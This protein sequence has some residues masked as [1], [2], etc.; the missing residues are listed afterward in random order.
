[1]QKIKGGVE[2]G[3]L[4]SSCNVNHQIRGIIRTILFFL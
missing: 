2:H 4:I 1:V 3:G